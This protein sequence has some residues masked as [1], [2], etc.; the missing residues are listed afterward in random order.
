MAGS[1]KVSLKML[2]SQRNLPFTT[3][4][5]TTTPSTVPYSRFTFLPHH[6]FFFLK[7][8]F[9]TERAQTGEQLAE[10]REAGSLLSREPLTGLDPRT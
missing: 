10:G 9:D 8:L 2:P 5:K 6:F 4:L 3:L 1:L 7:I